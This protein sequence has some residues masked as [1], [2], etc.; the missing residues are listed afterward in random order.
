MSGY[1]AKNGRHVVRY[2]SDRAKPVDLTTTE[3]R[4]LSP[5]L[6]LS[7]GA[8]PA[9]N[10][11]GALLPAGA[12]AAVATGTSDQP[13]GA[14]AAATAS[15]PSAAGGGEVGLITAAEA[16]AT[17]ATDG[18]GN[19]GFLP[20][21]AAAHVAAAPPAGGS[22]SSEEGNACLG[23]AISVLLPEYG[24]WRD[25]ACFTAHAASFEPVNVA[26]LHYQIMCI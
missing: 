11:G 26:Q 18:R 25:G 17:A 13:T 22:G 16:A 7:A 8:L 2:G 24:K 21:P 10:L 6:V 4:W 20:A 1:S 14:G 15:G 3:H 19:V 23:R 9:A 12:A 5:L